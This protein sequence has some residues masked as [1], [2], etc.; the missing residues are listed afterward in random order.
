MASERTWRRRSIA[1]LMAGAAA[2]AFCTAALAEPALGYSPANMDRSV[3]PR[4][5][6]YRYAVGGWLAHTEIPASEPDFGGFAQLGANLD[7]QLLGLIQDAAAASAPAG[8]PKQQIGDYYRAAMDLKRLDALGIEPLQADLAQLAT[9]DSPRALGV[10]AARLE[11]AY[12]GASPLVALSATD[13]KDVGR[14]LLVF[15]PG[16][17]ILDQDDY[18]KPEGERVRSLYI[19]Y[20][21]AMFRQLGDPAER[22]AEGARTVLSIETELAAARL[23]PLQQRDPSKTYNVMSF[24]EAQA[25]IPALDLSALASAL[26]VAPPPTVQIMDIAGVKAVQSVLSARSAAELSTWLRWQLLG[27]R[28]SLLGQPWRGF[29][30]EFDRQRKGLSAL[31][32]RER[33][34]TR[35]I[36]N[37]LFHPLSRLY[38]DA[39]FPESTRVEVSRMV[40]RIRGEFERRLRSNPWLDAPTRAAAL[41]KLAKVD[42]QV[43]YPREWI[44]FSG[45]AIRPDDHVG[46]NQRIDEF[47]LRRDLAQVG[48][49]PR[50]DRFAEPGKTTPISVNA[51]YNP[52]TNAIDITAAIVQPP[53]FKAGADPAVNYCTMGAVIG[54]ELTHG[55]DS[56]GR[57]FGPAGNLRNWWTPEATAAFERRTAVLAQQYG[58]FVLLPGL[59]HNGLLTLTENTA[60]LGGITLAHEALKRELGG[61]PRP[62][63]DGL[64]T[65]QRCFVAWAQ[66][67]AYKARP[68]RIRMLAA[69]DYHANSAL[70]GFAPLQHLD[71]FHRAFG[72]R[73][74]D[75][76]WRAPS[77]RVRIW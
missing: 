26:G 67:W 5:D 17:L 68:E 7:R 52:Q 71:D 22:A 11:A 54:H 55:F 46:N 56:F 6:F 59:K 38:V 51:A 57:Q 12:G 40:V 14:T 27:S 15:H 24:A 16:L 49:A 20:I 4:R 66:L 9:L 13:A 72:V 30:E 48:G 28:A 33:E 21:T 64:S 77:R 65:D 44:D 43:G 50:I 23:T 69:V 29:A 75:P 45:V 62:R 31:P 19:A 25:L 70:R 53:F 74:G 34:V 42:V 10:F 8:S 32:P 61:K 3:S 47:L 60:D 76:M 1:P 37:Q 2:L 35:A 63:I 18:A 58:E 39:Y 36:A 41:A 73:P